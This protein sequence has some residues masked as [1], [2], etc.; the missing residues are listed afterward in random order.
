MALL[1][2][3][4]LHFGDG[5]AR[6]AHFGERLAHFVELERFDDGGNAFHGDPRSVSVT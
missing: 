4:A 5:Q 3:E 6:E 2:A 1:A